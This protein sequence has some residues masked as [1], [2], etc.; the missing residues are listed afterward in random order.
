[1][2]ATTAA[3]PP[4]PDPDASAAASPADAS[5]ASG[6]HALGSYASE[7]PAYEVW[8]VP[9]IPEVRPGD[10]LAALVVRAAG[11][12]GRTLVD[13]DVLIVTSKIVSK[14]EG[15][16][17]EADD[18]DAAIDAETVRV[19]ARR[20]PARIVE[21]RHGFV[22]AAAGVDASNTPKGTV[23]LLPE[24]PDAA[25]RR[26]RDGVREALG[27]TVGVVVTDTFGRPW[28]EGLTDVAIGA[29]GVRVLEDLRGGVDA[30]GN[31]L[32]VTV[33]AV[34]DELAAAG[35]LVKGKA[36]GLPVAV[37]RGLAR[38]VLP[39]P[40]EGGDTEPAVTARALVRDAAA[41]MFR[42]GT[43]EAVREAVTLR[44]T[45][46]EFTADPVDGQAVRR[47]VAAAVTAPAPHHTTPWRFVLLESESS[48]LRLLDAMRDAWIAD[49]RA[50]GKSEESIAKRVKR[51]DVLRDAPYLAVPCLATDGAHAYPD[52][53]RNASE[54]EM[55]VVATG[56]GIQNFLVALAGEQ[57]GSAWISSTMFCRDV[58]RDVLELPADWDPM[59][60]VAIGRPAAPPRQRPARAAEDFVV[61]R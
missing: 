40:E 35:E 56:A 33:T 53:R 29:A 12:D 34:G 21:S 51:G 30:H 59:G 49:L 39:A 60:A 16:I 37:V 15:R 9:G 5:P 23:L 38:H 55:F 6:P 17:V 36:D 1:M 22:M 54:R 42:L 32:G 57:L 61:E 28:R 45:V 44:R 48:R 31:P 50:D 8:A 24:D 13:G 2:T 11:A 43:S 4:L 25:A 26:V 18:R 3:T 47:A 58:V 7:S 27:V 41:D 10:D 20:G 19:V 52:A 14:A 46:R